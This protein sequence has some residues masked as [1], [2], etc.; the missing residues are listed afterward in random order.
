MSWNPQMLK[1]RT[2]KG[3]MFLPIYL[4]NKVSYSYLG[5]FTLL[6]RGL[7]FCDESIKMAKQILTLKHLCIQHRE[8]QVIHV[9]LYEK[10]PEWLID[11]P[12]RH[13]FPVVSSIGF[14]CAGADCSQRSSIPWC[15]LAFASPASR[16][17]MKVPCIV[18]L[19]Q[20]KIFLKGLPFPV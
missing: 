8:K 3:N 2:Y 13:D 1:K 14:Q 16:T 7:I 19:T 5:D 15:H 17:V 9:K 18:H 12:H 11:E 20:Q 10:G 4:Y 6:V